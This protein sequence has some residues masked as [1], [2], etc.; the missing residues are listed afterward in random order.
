LNR[1]MMHGLANINSYIMFFTCNRS[2][3]LCLH[4]SQNFKCYC[5]FK[6]Y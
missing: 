6:S 2:L 3:P 1:M 4:C 5:I